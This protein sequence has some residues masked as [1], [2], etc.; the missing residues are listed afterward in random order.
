MLMDGRMTSVKIVTD[1]TAYIPSEL[2]IRYDIRVVPLNVVFGTTS[3]AEGVDITN[4]E[5]YDRLIHSKSLPATS[6]P[7]NTE[8]LKTYTDIVDEGNSVLSIHV[9]G[10]LSRT[11]KSA[12]SA[13]RELP[14]SQI[15]VMDSCLTAMAL[16]M[17][18]LAAGRAADEGQPLSEIKKLVAQ[19]VKQVNLLFAVDTLEYLHKGGH[20][21]STRVL[22]DTLLKIKPILCLK[23]GRIQPVSRIRAKPK[24]IECLLKLMEERVPQNRPVHVAIIHAQ[25]FDKAVALEKQVRDRFPC[26]EIHFSEVGPVIGTHVGPGAIG[27]AFYSDTGPA[28]TPMPQTWEQSTVTMQNSSQASQKSYASR[29][30]PGGDIPPLC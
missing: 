12:M 30:R 26:K 29:L 18:V 25:A 5:F 14:D 9:S 20:L 7:S 16:G 21:G 19:L 11:I 4:E 6:H 17:V 10:K 2:V 3:Y 24:V 15:E 27:L 13:S 28:P 22:L 1:S 23:D 8:F